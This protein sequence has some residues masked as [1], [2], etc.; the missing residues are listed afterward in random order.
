MQELIEIIS[1]YRPGFNTLPFL[2]AFTVL[3]I[4]YALY[5][6]KVKTRNIL[7]LLFSLGFYYLLSG[8]YILLLIGISASDYLIGKYMIG[9]SEQ[10]KNRLKNLAVCI[11]LGVLAWFKYIWFFADTGNQWFDMDITRPEGWITPVGI[12][13]YIFKSLTYIFDIHREEIET[14]ENSYPDYLL[15]V[16]FFPNI[17]A[18][19]IAFARDLLPQFKVH[20]IPSHADIGK[21]MFLILIG[22]IKKYA[23]ADR[24][25]SDLVDRVF[26]N[27]HLFAGIEHLMAAYGYTFQLYLDFSGYSDMMIGGALLF[28]IHLLPNFN[29]PFIAQNISEFWRRWHISLSKWFQE[30]VFMPIHFAWRSAGKVALIAAV[31]LT[32][33]LSGLWHGAA[34]TYVVWGLLHGLGIAWDSLG[35]G[36]RT[37]LKQKT[38]PGIWRVLSILLTFHFIVLTIILFRAAD[39]HLAM[40][41]Y[42][43]IFLH[44]NFALLPNWISGYS[45]PFTLI[46]LACILHYVPDSITQRTETWFIQ[47]HWVLKSC[48]ISAVILLIFQLMTSDTVPFQYLQY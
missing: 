48:I 44:P 19:P 30:Y 18:G 17:L 34:W 35:S 29:Q 22:A 40:E 39:M 6:Q 14:A 38:G 36:V 45:F 10:K 46:I 12:S 16:S 21:A 28:G 11:D 37:F 42:S 25:G 1:K 5:G 47:S 41:M 2:I 43:E 23:I 32:F 31:I 27:P 3:Y 13:F 4:V 24:L 8:K 26:E 15:Y 20:T 9:S 7:L 33:A